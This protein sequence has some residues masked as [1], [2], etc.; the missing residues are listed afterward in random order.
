MAKIQS[1]EFLRELDSLERFHWLMCLN[2]SNHIVMGAEISGATTSEMWRYALKELQHR[3]PF[4]NVFID[5]NANSK[6]AYRRF[7]GCDI[8]F[9][10]K[11]RKSSLQW[12]EEFERELA[13]PFDTSIAPLMR[14]LLL[15]GDDRCDIILVAHHTVVDGMSLVFI[16]RDLIEALLGKELEALPVPASQEQ[17][18]APLA[19]TMQSKEQINEA[20]PVHVIETTPK[21]VGYYRPRKGEEPHVHGL[22]LSEEETS[23]LVGRVREEK[24]TVHAALC[25]AL[26][27]ARAKDIGIMERKWSSR[28][29]AYQHP[30]STQY[31]GR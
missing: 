5:R 18:H 4:L 6:L 24:T 14:V 21:P 7:E 30:E 27:L 10:I 2:H 17:F 22:R 12:Q 29:V 11:D 19:A 13:V 16:M 20:N 8:P 31:R 26:V 1:S 9:I 28:F 25:A 23:L 3:H 15:K